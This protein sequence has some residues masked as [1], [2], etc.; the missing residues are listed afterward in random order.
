M[1][2]IKE[3][4]IKKVELNPRQALAV[5][6]LIACLSKDDMKTV[7]DGYI[8]DKSKRDVL[9]D[10]LMYMWNNGLNE[11]YEEEK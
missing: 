4:I 9:V 3:T 6:T 10:M 11:I 5:A 2:I 1:K 8:M 7:M